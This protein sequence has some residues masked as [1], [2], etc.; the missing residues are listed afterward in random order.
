[1]KFYQIIQYHQYLYS[2]KNI[3]HIGSNRYKVCTMILQL[4]FLPYTSYI[5]IFFSCLIYTIIF[6]IIYIPC[7][8]SLYMY[9]YIHSILFII[10][11]YI[12]IQTYYKEYQNLKIQPFYMAKNYVCVFSSFLHSLLNFHFDFCLPLFRLLLINFLYLFVTKILLLTTYYEDILDQIYNFSQFIDIVLPQEIKFIIILS[13][14]FLKL[15]FVEIKKIRI[16]FMLRNIVYNNQNLIIFFS[17]LIIIFW[18]NLLNYIINNIYTLYSR[19][20]TYKF[21]NSFNRYN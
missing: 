1:M 21:F 15:I 8:I 5:F 10:L 17:Y 3:L 18:N 7:K 13:S 14:Q 16:G 2:P 9:I 20:I 12:H 6:Q 4:T 11:N 19:G